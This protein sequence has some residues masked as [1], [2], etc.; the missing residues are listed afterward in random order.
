[1]TALF[2][3]EDYDV[4]KDPTHPNYEGDLMIKSP[5]QLTP[6]IP[7]TPISPVSNGSPP[8]NGTTS[9][10]W[11]FPGTTKEKQNQ[12]PSDDELFKVAQ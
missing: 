5:T 7:P 1:M 10:T 3:K 6:L 8:S 4:R 2:G 12:K 11:T 9:S